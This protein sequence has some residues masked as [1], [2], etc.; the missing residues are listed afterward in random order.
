MEK[1]GLEV[2]INGYAFEIIKMGIFF[3]HVW[4]NR[5]RVWLLACVA[6]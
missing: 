6:N 4:S 1:C 5:A 3:P 2:D